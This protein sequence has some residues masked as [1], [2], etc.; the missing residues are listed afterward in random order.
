MYISGRI[1]PEKLAALLRTPLF[2][3]GVSASGNALLEIILR[4]CMQAVDSTAASLFLA[5]EALQK[6]QTV[7]YIY[8][9]T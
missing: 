3:D 6:A 4:S 9:L 8:A 5:D 7:A 2:T 1:L